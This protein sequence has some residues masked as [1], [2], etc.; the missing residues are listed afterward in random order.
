MHIEL[1]NELTPDMTERFLKLYRTTF[2]PLDI[3]AAARQ[4]LTDEE[5]VEEMALPSVMK[6][7]GYD[8]LDEPVA[9]VFMSTD[10]STVPWISPAFY[11]NQFPEHYARGA[12]YY[13]GALLVHPDARHG[14]AMVRR[15]MRTVIRKI[16][17]DG[18]IAA[19]DCCGFNVDVVGLPRMIEKVG[20]QVCTVNTH[21]VD[22]QRYYAYEM[23]DP[24]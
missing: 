5:F 8:D 11:A 15:I 9:M 17:E 18:A 10:L 24:K 16:A 1:H 20:R 19:F 3:A 23:K 12:I 6:F 13:I 14:G 21:E 2:D 4:S 22:V 7:V